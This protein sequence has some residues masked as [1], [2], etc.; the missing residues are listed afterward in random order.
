MEKLCIKG[1]GCVL[2]CICIVFSFYLIFKN[3]T[4]EQFSPTNISLNS[5]LQNRYKQASLLELEEI[6]KY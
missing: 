4:T 5:N 3:F 1:S 6:S 2:G